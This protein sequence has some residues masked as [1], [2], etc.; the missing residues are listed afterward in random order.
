MPLYEDHV[1]RINA[2]TTNARNTWF[3]LLGVL[4]FVSITLMGVEDIDFYGVD[5][6]TKLPLVDVEVPTR[7][8]FVAASILSAAVYG[9]FHL[10]LIRL[11]DALGAAL[12]E[13]PGK[14]LA[15]NVTPWLVTDMAMKLRKGEA[16]PRAMDW[17]AFVLNML[18]AW[19]FGIFVL[20]WLWW[21]SA[22]AR[23]FWQT[24]IACGALIASAAT[25]YASARSLW[26]ILRHARLG[27]H[28]V[29]RELRFLAPLWV[30]APLLFVVSHSRTYEAS[31]WIGL[32]P[33]QLAEARLVERPE[34]WL[35]WAHA[36]REFQVEWCGREG[37]KTCDEMGDD[38][39]RFEAEWR[40]RRRDQV[41]TLKTPIINVWSH[42][43]YK[44]EWDQ[45][46]PASSEQISRLA[47]D[48]S[49]RGLR[50]KQSDL[51]G[52]FLS[53]I[54]LTGA[55]LS[56]SDLSFSDLESAK[57]SG[58]LL[59]N[60][61]LEGAKLQS[62]VLNNSQ[63]QGSI[64]WQAE[65]N[66]ANLL[67]AN[68][69]RA[70]LDSANLRNSKLGNS[71]M[72]ETDLSFAIL[73]NA[74]LRWADLSNS[75]LEGT[76]LLNAKIAGANFGS[77]ILD[78]SLI[79]GRPGKSVS[80]FGP[81]FLGLPTNLVK[82]RNSGGAIRFA[83]MRRAKFDSLTDFRNVFLDG[84]V[85]YEK[86]FASQ[87]SF[88]N[89]KPCQWVKEILIDEDFFG[90]WRWWN[91]QR[92]PHLI[93]ESFSPK[94]WKEVAPASP[95]LRAKYGIPDDCAWKTGPLKTF[96]GPHGP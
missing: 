10:Y 68:L 36:K 54:D 83:D 50:L 62:I 72:Q 79:S 5:R 42:K 16:R 80:F 53:G 77:A 46:L 76:Y 51:S 3:V 13:H 49:R 95:E 70:T 56:N 43:N 14:Q 71:T 67:Q 73:E 92:E 28:L 57:M 20:A 89:E 8:F 40:A 30:A 12:D 21:E 90:I 6:A 74:D 78:H 38:E 82:A 91:Q 26:L 25:G 85:L 1:T 33:V 63:M 39:A 84:S 93:W 61:A 47:E 7:L 59:K 81:L 60:T 88:P 58:A 96:S 48:F 65:L 87:M 2:L 22:T 15:D 11:W 31:D 86:R 17:P 64:L 27:G 55:D 37:I 29:T 18:L 69:S 52:A 19:V 24:A 45:F 34:G 23:T 41:R 66:N 35:N 9:Y 75:N 4:V 94:K 32:A 44:R